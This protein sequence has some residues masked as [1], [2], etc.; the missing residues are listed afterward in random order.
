MIAFEFDHAGMWRRLVLRG[1]ATLAG[2]ALLAAFCYLLR[3]QLGRLT[4]REGLLL[5]FVIVAFPAYQENTRWMDLL[6]SG[7]RRR[8][9]ALV[10]D[11]AGIVDNATEYALG[12]IAWSEIEKM[13]TGVW[14]TP[15]LTN[16]WKMPAV[17][18]QRGVVVV[19]K[20]GIDFHSRAGAGSK[21]ARAA[22]KS[23]LWQGRGRWLFVPEMLLAT[24]ADDVI[25]Q[26][27]KFYIAQVKGPL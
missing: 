19:L 22:L 17:D 15:L 24:T 4:W 3:F 25:K 23:Q 14:A 11:P 10:I 8:G 9:A 27:N 20:D 7:L 21:L 6:L 16:W 12:Q 13:H 1:M 5:A 18:R 2:F 26:L